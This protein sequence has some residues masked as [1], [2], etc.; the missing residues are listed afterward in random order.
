MNI[1]TSVITVKKHRFLF[2]YN[3]FLFGLNPFNA[4]AEF[5]GNKAYRSVCAVVFNKR[6]RIE[7]N[8]FSVYIS[9]VRTDIN[10]NR[11]V[12]A[13]FKIFTGNC[14]K[15]FFAVPRNFCAEIFRN[16]SCREHCSVVCNFRCN[17][18]RFLHCRKQA[19]LF[20]R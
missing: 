17:I 9:N 13:C 1:G 3:N 19:R 18:V 2:G 4:C 6:G 11:Y 12:L 7:F 20:R 8:L 16:K 15:F 14:H 5:L 10:K